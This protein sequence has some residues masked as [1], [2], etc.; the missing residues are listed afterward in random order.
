MSA[1]KEQEEKFNDVMVKENVEAVMKKLTCENNL[2][3]STMD[4][5]QDDMLKFDNLQTA[6]IG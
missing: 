6:L 4:Y 1:A 3:S 2:G 5:L